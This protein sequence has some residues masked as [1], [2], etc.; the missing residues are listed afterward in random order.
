M[1]K[2]DVCPKCGADMTGVTFTDEEGVVRQ[3]SRII[4][5]VG[6]RDRIEEWMC[7]DCDHKEP[8]G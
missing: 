1:S 4:G 3:T 5:C 2:F 6:G 8:R 7:P